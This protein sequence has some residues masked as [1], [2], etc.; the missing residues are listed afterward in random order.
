M[1]VALLRARP[2]A[3]RRA[4]ASDRRRGAPLVPLPGRFDDLVA[5]KAPLALRLWG[6]GSRWRPSG[7]RAVLLAVVALAGETGCLSGN[8]YTSPRVLDQGQAAFSSALQAGITRSSLK[9]EGPLASKVPTLTMTSKSASL[10]PS[11]FQVRLPVSQKT[12][13]GLR[14]AGVSL[15]PGGLVDLKVEVVRGAFDLALDPGFGVTTKGEPPL[16]REEPDRREYRM[17]FPVIIGIPLEKHE[18]VLT[19]AT[20][21]FWRAFDA[22]D[23]QPSRTSASSWWKFASGVRLVLSDNLALFPEVSATYLPSIHRELTVTGG[24]AF[25]LRG[26]PL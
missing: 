3:R 1:P 25:E 14:V 4:G 18:V 5:M 13:L 22:S 26:K 9:N 16:S 20:G 24:L 10:L 17:E 12:E 21:F 11:F 23:D 15:A 6:R 19:Q 8:A 2:R 7:P